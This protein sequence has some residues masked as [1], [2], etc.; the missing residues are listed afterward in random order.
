MLW[1]GPTTPGSCADITRAR[2]SGLV[3]LLADGLDLEI[4]ADPDVRRTEL[5]PGRASNASDRSGAA[6]SPASEGSSVHPW[7]SRSIRGHA[8]WFG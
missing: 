4:H 1:Y 6:T 3:K 8:G 7:S 2:R 5:V